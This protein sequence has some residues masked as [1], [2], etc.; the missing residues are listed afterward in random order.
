MSASV[1]S[2]TVATLQVRES[3]AGSWIDY[4]GLDI[5][6][7]S[8]DELNNFPKGTLAALIQWTRCGGTLLVTTAGEPETFAK[9]LVGDS[10]LASAWL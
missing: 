7:I 3:G 4:S 9:L 1:T 5:V 8:L 10:G 2:N 6:S